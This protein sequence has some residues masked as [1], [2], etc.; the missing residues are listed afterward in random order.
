MQISNRI[1][2]LNGGGSDGWD[3]FYK[4]RAMI[5]AGVDVTE[6]TIGEHDISTD[7]SILDAMHRSAS[8]GHTG[9][10]EVPGVYA[11]RDAVA[12]RVQA[13]TGMAT[14]RENVLITPGAQS[15]LFS[16]HH[17]TCDEG[18]VALFCDPYYATYPGTIRSVGA[19]PRAVP[20]RPQVAF[21]PSFGD[22][23]AKSSDAKSLLVNTPN[24][25]TG[26]VYSRDTVEGIARACRE[27]DMWCISDEVYDTQIW[28]GAH[29]SPR[30][31]D[32]MAERTLVVG[33]MSKS[34]AMTGSRVGWIIGPQETIAQLI[35][36][37]THTTYGVPGFV[38][39]AA[40]FALEQGAALE[41]KVAEPFR[42][43]R[44]LAEG[45]LAGQNHVGLVPSAGAMYLMLDCRSTGMSG[46]A[47]ALALLERHHIASM[48]GESFGASAKGHIRLAMTVNDDAFAASLQTLVTF[49]KEIQP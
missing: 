49:A 21:Q 38:Q 46:E 41:Q 22:I 29:I 28:D 44:A 33:S 11:L 5:A 6:L 43:R 10:A 15:A 24:N 40:V 7:Q 35:N 37:A 14:T 3:V 13:R 1:S 32:G 45:I 2:D 17:V 19:I 47:F 42:R 27:Y 4:A 26:V 36:L 16:A 20:C 12:A 18:D 31:M 23:A 30:M 48:P 9:Y 39:D 8:G 34:H 25:P